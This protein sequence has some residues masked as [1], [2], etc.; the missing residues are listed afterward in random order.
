M[1]KLYSTNLCSPDVSLKGALLQAF[2]RGVAPGP[3]A[4]QVGNLCLVHE[5]L[6]QGLPY[7]KSHAALAE[8]YYG[9]QQG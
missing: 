9:R 6:R 3:D 4:R 7:P 1:T 5:V 2:I 8:K